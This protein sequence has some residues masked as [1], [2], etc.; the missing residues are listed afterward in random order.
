MADDIPGVKSDPACGTLANENRKFAENSNGN[1][2]VRVEDEEAVSVLNDIL[3][4]LGGS[5]GTP[6]F[7]DASS[8]TTGAL[9]T[10]ISEVVPGGVTR[11]ISKVIVSSRAP[12]NFEVKIN[13]AVI[14][15]GR[16]GPSEMNSS[17]IFMP[18]RDAAATET[19]TVE[20]TQ[21]YG[22][23]GTDIEAYLMATDM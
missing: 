13:G 18:G 6:F 23:V 3:L 19:I 4:Q 17:F 1:L 20:F 12:G 7:S 21:A 15:S 14:G 22:K 5:A 10:L 2:V 11:T 8:T 16:T 9:Q